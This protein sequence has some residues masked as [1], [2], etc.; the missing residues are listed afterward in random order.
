[1]VQAGFPMMN[2]LRRR[3]LGM[4]DIDTGT[5]QAHPIASA[6]PLGAPAASAGSP[7]EA[8]PLMHVPAA[9]GPPAAPGVSPILR[10]PVSNAFPAPGNFN[11]PVMPPQVMSQPPVYAQ[12][13]PIYGGQPQ[14]NPGQFNETDPNQIA[15]NFLRRRLMMAQ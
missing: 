6:M 7:M 10:S 9:M 15:Q 3:V 11:A 8:N 4:G 1:M 14:M 5:M 2:A 12:P 13:N